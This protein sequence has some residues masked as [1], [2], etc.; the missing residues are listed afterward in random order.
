[1]SELE[2]PKGWELK[3]FGDVIDNIVD[4]NS[5]GSFAGLAKNVKRFNEKNFSIYNFIFFNL[6][7]HFIL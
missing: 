6:L 1:M 4:F 7:F 5:N 3:S 2:I